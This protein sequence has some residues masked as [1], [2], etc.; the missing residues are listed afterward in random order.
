MGQHF[1]SFVTRGFKENYMCWDRHGEEG[2]NEVEEGCLN[3]GESR[4]HAEGAQRCHA[5]ALNE[6]ETSAY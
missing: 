4:H 1:S 3:K 2:L 6:G 5:E